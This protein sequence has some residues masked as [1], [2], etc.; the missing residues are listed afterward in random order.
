[1]IRL[2]KYLAEAGIGTRS[3]VKK[4]I[5]DGR[6]KIN[7]EAVKHADTKVD[8][9]TDIVTFDEEE[10][11]FSEFVYIMLNKPQG[12]ISA[13]RGW[14][15]NVIDLIAE[16]F[17]NLF[18]VGRLDKDT[19]GLLL[20]TN[21]GQLAH[22]LLAPKKLIEKEYYTE[23]DIPLSEEDIRKIETGI[24]WHEET[25][26][27]AVYKKISDHAMTLS[28]TEGKYHEIKRMIQALGSRV[29]Y[30]KRIRMKNLKLDESLKPGEYRFL[31][32]DELADLRADG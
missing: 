2:D 21:D 27:P 12:Y 29:T 17:R 30:L 15:P 5:R 7:G 8:E 25:Y 11:F 10:V 4:M 1:M 28:V 6:V 24:S 31:S 16:P 23:V 32:E 14:D 20:I 19:E 18:P 26:R 3:Q 13:S 9:E 22:E